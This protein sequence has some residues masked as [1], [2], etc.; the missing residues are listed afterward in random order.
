M[1]WI[2]NF[3]LG[4]IFNTALRLIIAG[5]GI[6]L[7]G[8]L[9]V[10]FHGDFFTCASRAFVS[11]NFSGFV[12]AELLRKLLNPLTEES[13]R[14]LTSALSCEEEKCDMLRIAG[15]EG[16]WNHFY[17][18][19]TLSHSEVSH[20]TGCCTALGPLLFHGLHIVTSNLQ[21]KDFFPKEDIY[22]TRRL[23]VFKAGH[24]AD[25]WMETVMWVWI[26][27]E[28]IEFFLTFTIRQGL[29]DRKA[30]WCQG[31]GGRY[32]HCSNIRH[33]ADSSVLFCHLCS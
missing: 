26:T 8:A 30:G 15:F 20:G 6:R 27:V 19:K 12:A 29:T 13:H 31:P 7:Q 16:V 24:R 3:L 11:C 18:P 2:S 9:W 25:A 17:L 14:G 23:S 10:A 5:G 32:L 22:L 21:L 4:Q 33:T 28:N 1:K